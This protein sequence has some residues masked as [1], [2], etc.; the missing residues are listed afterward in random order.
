MR[1][2]GYLAKNIALLTIVFLFLMGQGVFASEV[3]VKLNHLLIEPGE[4]NKLRVTEQYR[5][6]N[7]EKITIV[8]GEISFPLL[9]GASDIHYGAGVEEDKTFVRGESIVFTQDLPEGETTL[10]FHYLLASHGG[11][12]FHWDR[13]FNHDIPTF[14]IIVPAGMLQLSGEGLYDQGITSMGGRQLHIYS[15]AFKKGEILS[16][17][18]HPGNIA[19]QPGMVEPGFADRNIAP[20]LHSKAHVDR[21]KASPLGNVE[22]HLF[23]L[24]I[25][26]IPLGF[27]GR[28][29][30]KKGQ[31]SE[32]SSFQQTKGENFNELKIKEKLLKQKLVQLEQD[33]AEGIVEKLEYEERLAF[34]KKKLIEVRLKLEGR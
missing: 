1:K 27:L 7:P 17:T 4:D 11:D 22:P 3:E 6:F 8:D 23:M 29:L 26:G 34:Y 19:F 20:P 10:V 12:H 33:F 25:V 2:I 24:I 31:A 16:L 21:W 18:I 28:Y 13:E 14:F 9:N 30:F 5:V 32:K 15:G